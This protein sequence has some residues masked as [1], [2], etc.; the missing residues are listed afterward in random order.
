VLE[1]HIRG[2]SPEYTAPRVSGVKRVKSKRLKVGHGGT[3]DPSATG[4]LVV[5]IGEACK[6]LTSYLAGSKGY[7]CVAELGS[8]T[9]TLDGDGA[10]VES[11]AWDHVTRDAIDA[12]LV[13][14]RGDIFQIPPMYSALHHNGQRLHEL[15]R[16]GVEVERPARAAVIHRL[17][18]MPEAEALPRFGLE[19][20]CGGGTYIRSLVADVAVNVGTVGYMVSLER[21]KQG[22]FSLDHCIGKDQW[23]YE[24]LMANAVLCAEVLA[25]SLEEAKAQAAAS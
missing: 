1:K 19:V 24:E 15:A 14:F 9:D 18:L 22:P 23:T 6:D 21:T 12:A 3:L 2:L 13:H 8:A 4:V 17:Q 11:K 16:A 5:G 25:R 20:E 10:V 7:T